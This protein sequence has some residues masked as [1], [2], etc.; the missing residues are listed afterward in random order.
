MSYHILHIHEHGCY[1]KLNNRRL[2]LEPPNGRSK[3]LPID[4]LKALLIAAKGVSISSP[5]LAAV[6]ANDSVIVHCDEKFQ[7]V[8]VTHNTSRTVDPKLLH[9]QLN[10][11]KVLV[12]NLWN[13]IVRAK[14]NN[15]REVLDL[16]KQDTTDIDA[17]LKRTR[18]DES[19]VARVYW[20]KFFNMHQIDDYRRSNRKEGDLNMLLNYGYAVISS[21]IHRSAVV[22]GLLTHIG[23]KHKPS[24]RGQPLVYDLMEPMRPIVD[25]LVMNFVV[26]FGMQER[27]PEQLK[28]TWSKYLGLGLVRT[29]L[30]YS[31]YYLKLVNAVDRYMSSYVN[32]LLTQ[33]EKKLWLPSLSPDEWKHEHISIE[34]L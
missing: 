1:L 10:P 28:K 12:R 22:H 18:I 2:H 7:P 13:R 14:A 9:S 19:H 30:N 6:L 21:L 17:I 3:S 31:G 4:D 24:Y 5:L 11:K 27:K 16:G 29:K 8:G 15:Q 32:A 33:T 25:F 26:N 34:S 23:I 20:Q